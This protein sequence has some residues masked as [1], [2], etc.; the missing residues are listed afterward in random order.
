MVMRG[1]ALNLE[2]RREAGLDD[3][4]LTALS[5]WKPTADALPRPRKK[6]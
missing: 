2:S 4:F 1:N 5:D 3:A 6:V